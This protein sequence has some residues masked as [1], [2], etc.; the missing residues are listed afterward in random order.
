[1]ARNRIFGLLGKPIFCLL[2]FYI[3][4]MDKVYRVDKIDI[5]K[6]SLTH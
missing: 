2:S 1:M 5:V 4:S 3:L 6:I